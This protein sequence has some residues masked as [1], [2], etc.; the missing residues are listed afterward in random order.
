MKKVAIFVE[1]QTE[2]IFIS[3][4]I[5]QLFGENKA[6]IVVQKNQRKHEKIII[7]SYTTANNKIYDFLISNCGNDEMVKSKIIDNYEKLLKAGFI[8]IIG[9]QDLY[10]PQ[11]KKKGIDDNIYRKNINIGLLQIIP[12]K[13]YLA[14]QETEAWFIAEDTHYQKISPTLTI[15]IVNSITGLDVQKDDTEIIPH[16]SV[17]LDKIYKTGGRSSGYSKNE[18]VV[19]N[20]VSKL[21]FY[22]LYFSVRSRNSSLN[23]LLI[24]LDELIP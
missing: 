13:I 15:D 8:N 7:D 20:V 12:T 19:I 18:Y 24:C 14:I 9:L 2:A 4:M 23:E 10:N 21:D 5:R 3:E 6:D 1:G 16:P 17:I 22:N 11:R